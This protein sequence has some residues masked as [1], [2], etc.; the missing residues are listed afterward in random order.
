MKKRLALFFITF[1]AS[2]VLLTAFWPEI[3]GDKLNKLAAVCSTRLTTVDLA[4]ES[5][6]RINRRTTNDP[7][8]T[9]E[10]LEPFLGRIPQCPCG[11][12]YLPGR[13]GERARC[14]LKPEEHTYE[15][16]RRARQQASGVG[17]R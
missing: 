6:A 16:E 10:Q 4:K 14:S 15:R 12:A 5:W 11:G 7:A 13:V 1:A 17:S 8:P 9:L 3:A 2:A